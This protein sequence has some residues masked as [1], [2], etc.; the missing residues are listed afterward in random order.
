MR[1]TPLGKLEQLSTHDQLL[2]GPRLTF[3]GSAF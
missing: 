2:G 1:V 3:I